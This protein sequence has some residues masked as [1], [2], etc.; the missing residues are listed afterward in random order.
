[1]K[2]NRT[3]NCRLGTYQE[4]GRFA[5]NRNTVLASQKPMVSEE[6]QASRR[7]CPDRQGGLSRRGKVDR[8]GDMG[9]LMWLILGLIVTLAV[10]VVIISLKAR[11]GGLIDSIFGG[12]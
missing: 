4:R 8:K 11:G 10:I 3:F 5:Q 2:N 12:G 6:V 7:S 1:M 9:P